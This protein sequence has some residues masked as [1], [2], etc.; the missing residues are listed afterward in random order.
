MTD[1]VL[2]DEFESWG[3]AERVD[4]ND[5]FGDAIGINCGRREAQPSQR[6]DG[7]GHTDASRSLAAA[8]S[9]Q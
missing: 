9:P 1:K 7:L 3:L 5:S 4:G 8:S 6:E 2:A